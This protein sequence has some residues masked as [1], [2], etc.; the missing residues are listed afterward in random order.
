MGTI[1]YSLITAS[2]ALL[3]TAPFAFAEGSCGPKGCTSCNC[4]ERCEC[5]GDKEKCECKDCKCT[6]EKCG[7]NKEAKE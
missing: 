5:S 6:D 2:L 3:I 7:C 1:P 4:E